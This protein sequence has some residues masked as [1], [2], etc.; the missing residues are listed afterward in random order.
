MAP[1]AHAVLII[2]RAAWHTMGK[3]TVPPNITLLLLPA[4][5][6]ELNPVENIWLFTR[7][8]WLS[9]RIFKSYDEIVTIYCEAWNK[10]IDQP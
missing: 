5:V 10:L 1:G 9:N 3:F 2:V 8:D 4:R 6:P 7:D